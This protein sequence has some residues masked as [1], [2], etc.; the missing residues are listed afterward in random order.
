MALVP[1]IEAA[2]MSGV[3]L[4][5]L[6]LLIESGC[7]AAQP[8]ELEHG[9]VYLVESA[10][11]AAIPANGDPLAEALAGLRAALLRRRL[12]AETR[13][14]ADDELPRPMRR[15]AR[16]LSSSL[17]DAELRALAERVDRLTRA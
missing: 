9:S 1:L 4:E 14:E 12:Q 10:Q 3:P 8:V 11:L 2:G 17:G 13:L 15:P 16:R 5:Q 7:L 6:R